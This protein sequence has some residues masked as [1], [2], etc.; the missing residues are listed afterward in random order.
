M[1][2][3]DIKYNFSMLYF[4]ST[5]INNFANRVK[6]MNETREEPHLNSDE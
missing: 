2:L 3:P 4:Y 1:M 5:D 6:Q